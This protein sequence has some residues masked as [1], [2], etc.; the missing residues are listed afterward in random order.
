MQNSLSKNV[1]V[2]ALV[3][4]AAF[5]LSFSFAEGSTWYGNSNYG[6]ST[7]GYNYYPYSYQHGINYYPQRNT[8]PPSCMITIKP[9]PD[10]YP[11]NSYRYGVPMLLT[12][13]AT[14]ADI[15]SISPTV[16]SVTPNG[17]RVV[18][19][20]GET[21]SMSVHGYGGSAHCQTA[22]YNLPS[23]PYGSSNYYY[24][25]NTQYPYSYPTYS[26]NVTYVVGTPAT[27]SLNQ[28]PYTGVGFGIWG[29]AAMWL[30]I[31]LAAGFGAFALI[32]FKKKEVSAILER[33]RIR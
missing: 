30:A 10:A 19:A 8:T 33:V 29:I 23:Y 27:I 17:S 12:W 4:V 18:Y 1:S 28:I 9:S 13:T 21:Y 25:A 16:G 7:Y 31:I 15:A 26:N 20:R 32:R 14:N 22:S 2:V 11:E 24:S 3:L 6:Q 5:S